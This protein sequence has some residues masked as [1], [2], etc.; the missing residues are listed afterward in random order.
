[1]YHHLFN[2]LVV[3]VAVFVGG[4]FVAAVAAACGGCECMCLFTA[5]SVRIL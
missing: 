5:S 1:M 3:M 4:G 2:W